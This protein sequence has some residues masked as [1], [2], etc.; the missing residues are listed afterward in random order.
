M[1]TTFIDLFAG[2]GGMRKGL[3]EAAL[4]ADIGVS[5]I[6]SSEIDKHAR[7]TYVANFPEG[8]E[9]EGDIREIVALLGRGDIG[10]RGRGW[11]EQL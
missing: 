9:P 1:M 7:Q 6:F 2:I 5:C 8:P 4:L 3:E 11:R 10:S